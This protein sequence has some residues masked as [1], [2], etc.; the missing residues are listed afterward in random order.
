MLRHVKNSK[1]KTAFGSLM[2]Q[3]SFAS[4]GYRYGFNGKE[5]D[6]EVKGNGNQQDYGF[7]IYDSR[8]AK[9]LSVDP[10]TAEYPEL[11]PYQF[12][13]N[14]PIDGVDLDGLEYATFTIFA[15]EGKVRAIH[16]ATD[17]ELKAQNTKG[18]GVQ[19]KYVYLDK[20]GKVQ[21]VEAKALVKNYHGIYQGPNN[22]QLPKVGGSPS[23]V[24]DDYSLSPLDETDKIAKQHDIDYDKAGKLKGI[25][26]VM[27][28]RSTKANE[29]YIKAAD[30]II[31]KYEKGR[32]DTVTGKPVTKET[33]DAASFGR[34]GFKKAE[35]LKSNP[36]DSK[37]R[38]QFNERTPK[39]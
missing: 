5:N 30:G 12:A 24:F 16:V 21:K 26:G 7:R 14:R 1:T 3:R 20:D 33:K 19:Y 9:F 29:D 31:E 34:G 39:H 8:I 13:S 25:E 11:T 10:I 18:P 23:E 22:P 32:T 36:A 2:P 6:N 27:D 28:S 38:E 35:G 17:Y 4:G 37:T 15:Q